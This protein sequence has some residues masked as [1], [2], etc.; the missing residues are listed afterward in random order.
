[1][2]DT[3]MPNDNLFAGLP[4]PLCG[5]AGIGESLSM[6]ASGQ[7]LSERLHYSGC[8]MHIRRFRIDWP[9]RAAAL[10][11]GWKARMLVR[12]RHGILYRIQFSSA[13]FAFV[14]AGR[15]V[16]LVGR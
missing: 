8:C 4:R 12:P 13:L 7:R 14:D 15:S 10:L 6:K 11:P 16:V 5:T 2:I 1:M 9:Q 3:E